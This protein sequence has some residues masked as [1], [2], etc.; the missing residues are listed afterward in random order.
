M[1]KLVSKIPKQM[2]VFV[3]VLITAGMA[4]SLTT[5]PGGVGLIVAGIMIM[6][7]LFAVD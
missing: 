2:W 7:T 3:I 1:K 6:L 4:L 5:I